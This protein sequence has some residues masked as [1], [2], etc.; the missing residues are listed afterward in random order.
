[1]ANLGGLAL[2]EMLERAEHGS[3]LGRSAGAPT[4][5]DPMREE[6]DAFCRAVENI[7]TELEGGA[8]LPTPGATATDAGG[9]GD[10]R[11]ASVP[12]SARP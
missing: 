2:A 11:R 1:M 12:V 7:V 10:E 4:D 9:G 6:L 8:A 3:R 5:L